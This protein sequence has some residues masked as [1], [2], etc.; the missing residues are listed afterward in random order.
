MT[1]TDPLAQD[2][3][4]AAVVVEIRRQDPDGSRTAQ[5]IRDTFHQLYDGGRSGGYRGDQL[6][7][8]EKAHFGT[9]V[10]INLQREFKYPD[11]KKLDYIVGHEV[12]AK[13]SQNIWGLDAPARGAGRALYGPHGK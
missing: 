1:S 11:G 12:D 7:K 6:F 5:V 13:Y 8:I 3:P 2:R 9:V 10:A 4:L